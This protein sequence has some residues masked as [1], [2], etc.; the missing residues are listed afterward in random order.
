VIDPIPAAVPS[1][2]DGTLIL[3]GYASTYDRDRDG[4]TVTPGALQAALSGYLEN[5]VVLLQH[6]PAR[7]IGRVVRGVVDNVGLWVEAHVPPPVAEWAREAY[8]KIKDGV[9]KAFSIG[10]F[11]GRK[12]SPLGIDI[13]DLD[14]LEISV[15]AVPSNRSALFT[16][17][18]KSARTLLRPQPGMTVKQVVLLRESIRDLDVALDQLDLKLRG[19]RYRADLRRRRIR[20]L[21]TR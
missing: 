2:A 7:P 10:G 3:R 13:V 20:R 12:K 5:P 15:V 1:Q 16:A 17:S 9:L 4:E 19:D 6:D 8:R 21:H 18:V 14:L 11:F